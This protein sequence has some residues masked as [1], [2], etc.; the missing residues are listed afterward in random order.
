MGTYGTN[1]IYDEGSFG[2][3]GISI[4]DYGSTP[5]EQY[6]AGLKDFQGYIKNGHVTDF[7]LEVEQ[8]KL[9]AIN[10]NA[11]IFTFDKSSIVPDLAVNPLQMGKSFLSD[12]LT[13]LRITALSINNSES[14]LEITIHDDEL[15]RIL[16]AKEF[17]ENKIK[18]LLPWDVPIKIGFG[19]AVPAG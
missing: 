12:Y 15:K 7:S 19:H 6:K 8:Q 17:Y 16:N 13:K 1:A 11:R 3:F 14:V 4:I 2:S 9:C 5:L 18:Q 10:D